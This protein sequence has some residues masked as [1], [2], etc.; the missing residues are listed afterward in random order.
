LGSDIEAAGDRIHIHQ[1]QGKTVMVVVKNH[2]LSQA[3]VGLAIG[4]GTDVAM[5]TAGVILSSGS[6]NGVPKQSSSAGPR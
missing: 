3:N 1:S 4:T 2:A 6:L 5:E